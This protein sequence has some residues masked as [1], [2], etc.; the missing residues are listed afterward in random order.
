[1]GQKTVGS[2]I[3]DRA[4]AATGEVSK[5]RHPELRN[6]E[7]FAETLKF[8]HTPEVAKGH[9]SVD[10]PI[11]RA[12]ERRRLL[13]DARF[14]EDDS[15]CSPPVPQLV[16]A[17]AVAVDTLSLGH[18]KEVVNNE[19]G[20][21]LEHTVHVKNAGVPDGEYSSRNARLPWRRRN[22]KFA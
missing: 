13:D 22:G 16:A 6:A 7:V 11:N 1:M 21:F 8:R 15:C 3:S 5:P 10:V 17:S 2:Q 9:V 19:G 14:G 12:E 20:W 18:L 4:P